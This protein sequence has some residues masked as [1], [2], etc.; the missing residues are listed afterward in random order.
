MRRHELDESCFSIRWT[1][2]VISFRRHEL[3]QSC[4]TGRNPIWVGHVSH[5]N[6]TNSTIMY[7]SRTQCV[8]TN[9]IIHVFSISWIQWVISM[10]HHE[11]NEPCLCNRVKVNVTNSICRH[12]L[13]KSCLSMRQIQRVISMHRHGTNV[14]CQCHELDASS[15]VESQRLLSH[16]ELHKSC[17]SMRH[18]FNMSSRTLQIMSLNETHT[19]YVVT[20]STNHVSQWDTNSIC[21]HELY[22]SCLSM[23]HTLNMSSR[24]LQIMSLNETHTTLGIS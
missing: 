17:L 3:N 24:T 9:C 13:Y 15:V 14:P 20:N 4:H 10:H 7:M 11:P 8:I 18:T 22:K 16:W 2:W 12:E 19:Q 21:R 23:R 1:Q 6:V 5:V